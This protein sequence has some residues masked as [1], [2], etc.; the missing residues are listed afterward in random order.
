MKHFLIKVLIDTK[1][2]VYRDLLVRNDSTLEEMHHFIKK[3]F[4]FKGNE[5]ASFIHEEETWGAEVEIPLEN[6][7][8]EEVSTMKEIRLS[9]LMQEVGDQL[10]YTYDYASEWKFYLELIEITSAIPDVN[11]PVILKSYGVAPKEEDRKITGEDAESILMNALLGDELSE[12]DLTDSFD[13]EEMDSIDD[14]EEY[15]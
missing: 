2:V 4:Q 8:D 14:Y 10:S 9:E 11:V 12:D 3:A 7:G 6:L 1:E 5:F 15:L 13:S